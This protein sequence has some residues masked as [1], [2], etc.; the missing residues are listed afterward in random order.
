MPNHCFVRNFFLFLMLVP[1]FEKMSLFSHIFLSFLS[2][3]SSLIR[4]FKSFQICFCR[5]NLNSFL[6]AEKSRILTGTNVSYLILQIIQRW[7]EWWSKPVWSRACVLCSHAAP[8]GYRYKCF[9]IQY[10]LILQN[11]ILKTLVD[12]WC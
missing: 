5:S 3:F 1:S 7:T 6:S 4:D 11:E 10:S 8:L 9:W 2:V 12:H